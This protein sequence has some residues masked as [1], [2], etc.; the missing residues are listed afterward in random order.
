MTAEERKSKMHF[1]KCSAEVL[2]GKSSNPGQ[3]LT[4]TLFGKVFRYGKLILWSKRR[5][6]RVFARAERLPADQSYINPI[7]MGCREF[8]W[9][10]L[11]EIVVMV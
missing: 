1:F 6:K 2:Q 10:L 5:W 11:L 8:L 9:S 4:V 3:L 7:R